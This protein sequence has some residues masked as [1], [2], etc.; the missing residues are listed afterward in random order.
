MPAPH[1]GSPPGMTELRPPAG[2]AAAVA[3]EVARLAAQAFRRAAIALA[4]GFLFT[5]RVLVQR[6]VP[7]RYKSRRT[8]RNR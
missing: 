1:F 7:F 5:L 4:C 6:V 8:P 2:V 3:D